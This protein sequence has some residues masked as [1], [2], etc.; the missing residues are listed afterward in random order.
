VRNQ[1]PSGPVRLSYTVRGPEL[2]VALPQ[3]DTAAFDELIGQVCRIWNGVGTLLL[4]V[5]VDGDV[6]GYE[7]WLKMLRPDHVYLHQALGEDVERVLAHDF[8]GRTSRWTSRVLER[9]VHPWWLLGARSS[10]P[11]V[12][13]LQPIADSPPLQR[14]VRT[15]WGDLD[16]DE[17]EHARRHFDVERVDHD[18]VQAL[19]HAQID[20]CSPLAWS[21][22][23]MHSAECVNGGPQHIL[24]IFSEDPSTD[25]LLSFWNAR[26]RIQT[27]ERGEMVVGLPAAALD[28]PATLALLLPWLER[29]GVKPDVRVSVSTELA[30]RAEQALSDAGLTHVDTGR[31]NIWAS[32]PPDRDHPEFTIRQPLFPMKLRRG[33]AADAL[34]GLAEGANPLHLSVPERLPATIFWKGLM[35]VEFHGLPVAFPITDPLARACINEA[36]AADDGGLMVAV[37][38]ATEPLRLDLRLPGPEAQLHAHLT[39][40]GLAGRESGAGRIA[41]TLLGRLPDHRALDALAH[42]LAPALLQALVPRSRPKLAQHVAHELKKLEPSVIVDEQSIVDLLRDQGLFFELQASTLNEIASAASRRSTELLDPLDGLVS[43]AV[44]QRGRRVAC[45]RCRFPDYWALRELD[46][47]LNCRACRQ[48]FTLPAI[49]GDREAPIAYRLDGLMARVMDQDLLPV[50]L[51]LRHLLGRSS[52]PEH[53]MSWPGLDLFEDPDADADAEVDLLLASGGRLHAAECKLDAAWLSKDE[54]ARH[55]ELADRLQAQP[56]FGALRGEWHPEVLELAEEG[57]YLLGPE[58]LLGEVSA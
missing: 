51:T 34:V 41:T 39:S 1:V 40:C 15:L 26:A 14:L 43:S 42:P 44:L 52:D 35:R 27:D 17:L 21:A 30:E 25:E 31:W 48:D 56:V 24:F 10:D 38:A 7:D 36:Q 13:L 28:Q 45:P 50:L 4:P 11:R 16:E 19:V 33:L 47:E 3:H 58:T 18:V 55:L 9:E 2:A 6:S 22:R 32:I 46:E 20:R 54:A 8:P 37:G 29:S 49:E 53:A 5:A 23:G 12:R 57:A